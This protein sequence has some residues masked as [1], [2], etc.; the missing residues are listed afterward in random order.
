MAGSLTVSIALAT[1][2]GEAYLAGQLE[3]YLQQRRLP[4][5]L[6]ISDDASADRTLSIAREFAAH[7]PF[8]VR[9]VANQYTKGYR[10][11]FQTAIEAA[12][13][14]II[15]MSDQDDVWLPAHIARLAETLEREPDVLAVASDSDCVD[16]DLN[17]LGYTMRQSERLSNSLLEATMRRGLDQF[18]LVLRHRAATGHAMALRR[19]FAPAALPFPESWGHDHWIFLLGAALGKVD[20]V[21]ESLTKY[22]QHGN[23]TFGGTMKSVAKWAEQMHGQPAAESAA[24]VARWMELL[25]RLQ[26][27]GASPKAKRL[28]QEKID[29]LAFRA[30]VRAM[31]IHSRTAR[32]TANLFRGRYHRLGRGF[33]A[34]ARDLRG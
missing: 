22:R 14:E 28:L 3:S 1:Y 21:P 9:I 29:F 26:R 31:P 20:Y 12:Q 32:T 2:N 25:E 30:S 7:A 5:E 10:G 27:L 13:G 8:A 33:Y 16:D 15:A 34:F 19:S 17:P 11:N 6:I 24:E 18:E 4:D 23:Q